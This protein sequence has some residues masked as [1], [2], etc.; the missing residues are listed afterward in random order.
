M[1]SGEG[2]KQRPNEDCL[3]MKGHRQGG[4]TPTVLPSERTHRGGTQPQCNPTN[5]HNLFF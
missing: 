3:P 4:E 1:Q 5:G 2:S